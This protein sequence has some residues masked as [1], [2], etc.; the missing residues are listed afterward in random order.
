[1]TENKPIAEARD[2]ETGMPVFTPE[3]SA[4]AV[5]NGMGST[6]IGPIILA[7]MNFGLACLIF[8]FGSYDKY[9]AKVSMQIEGDYHWLFLGAYMFS[10][11]VTFLNWYPVTYKE[12]IMKGGNFRNN[13]FIYRVVGENAPKGKVVL[14]EEGLI[15][16]Y[17][18]AN[19]A[20]AHFVENSMAIPLSAICAGLVFPFP[21]FILLTLIFV[22]RVFH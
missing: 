5:K 21:V 3:E 18:R 2:Q 22:G 6:L 8:F 1:M 19:R 15:G 13:S 17:N 12:A 20:T 10:R 4:K 7:F 11:L 14:E 16:N 9:V